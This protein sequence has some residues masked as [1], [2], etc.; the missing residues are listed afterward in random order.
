MADENKRTPDPWAAAKEAGVY[1][2]DPKA[3]TASSAAAAA[4]FGSTAGKDLGSKGKSMVG[5]PKMADFG[6]D[7]TAYSEAMR[8]FRAG[9][10][11]QEALKK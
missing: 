3:V 11:Q 6:G 8:K 1:H 4:K 9:Q 7:V 2:K 10:S 5:A